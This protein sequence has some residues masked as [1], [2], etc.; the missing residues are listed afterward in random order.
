MPKGEFKLKKERCSNVWNYRRV[1]PELHPTQKPVNLIKKIIRS[2]TEEN[3]TVLD[4]FIGSGTTAV[5]CKQ[6]NRNFI[7]IEINPDYVEIANR[8]LANTYRQME[9]IK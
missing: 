6:L 9:L 4:P 5:A 8:R 2:A 3:D 1:K 7:G